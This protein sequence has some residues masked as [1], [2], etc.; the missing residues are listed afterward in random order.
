MGSRSKL[1][2]QH[3][4]ASSARQAPLSIEAQNIDWEKR[5][6]EVV[7]E[8]STAN[9]KL[10]PAQDDLGYDN[11]YE[12]LLDTNN[13]N[14][15][16]QK[17]FTEALAR[18]PEEKDALA[19]LGTYTLRRALVRQ[20]TP[21]RDLFDKL[22]KGSDIP[23]VSL[24]FFDG[25]FLEVEIERKASSS[26]N[27]GRLVGRVKGEP[28]SQVVMGFYN[29]SDAAEIYIPTQAKTVMIQPYDDS[30]VIVN[31]IDEVAQAARPFCS[32]CNSTDPNH[33][34]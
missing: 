21:L 9:G 11:S 14:V 25:E 18:T 3:K 17:S 23:I 27:S 31:H 20:T 8:I 32:Q 28:L 19:D 26:D 5:K 22:R 29:G 6:Q 30:L 1:A 2:Q 12:T 4:V 24:P 33:S 15:E 16:S 10:Y 7:T 13:N 34:H